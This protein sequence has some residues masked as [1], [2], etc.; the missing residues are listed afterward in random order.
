MIDHNVMR[1]DISMH[2]SFAVTEIESFEELKDVESNINVVKL[3]VEASEIGV[4]DV[5][6]DERWC[7]ALFAVRVSQ[8]VSKD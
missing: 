2:N 8:G 5:L 1:L 6:E 3:G 4:V 7:L